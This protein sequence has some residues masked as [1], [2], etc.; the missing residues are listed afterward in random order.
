LKK[1]EWWEDE[2]RKGMQ[3]RMNMKR[4]EER[5]KKLIRVINKKI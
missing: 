1:N 3:K 5:V 2:K 4:V